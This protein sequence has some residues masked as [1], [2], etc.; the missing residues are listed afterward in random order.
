MRDRVRYIFWE[1]VELIW[2]EE[3]E[4]HIARHAVTPEEVHEVVAERYA[5]VRG[6]AGVSLVYGRTRGGRPLLVVLA[7]TEA[8]AATVVTARDLTP[9]ERRSV[10][11]KGSR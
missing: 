1:A 8:G 3:S 10:R 7:P 11:R 4:E 9:A 5:R 2:S 6:R